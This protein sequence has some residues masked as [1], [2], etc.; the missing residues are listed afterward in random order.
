LTFETRETK[1]PLMY[2]F[3][4]PYDEE[5]IETIQSGEFIQAVRVAEEKSRAAKKVS[6][7]AEGAESSVLPTAANDL[8]NENAEST[9]S[10][11]TSEA[12]SNSDMATSGS[13]EV[14]TGDESL[15][16]ENLE[17]ESSSTEG[18]EDSLVEDSFSADPEDKLRLPDRE[19][20]VMG[21]Q[22]QNYINGNIVTS[23]P[24]PNSYDKWEIDFKIEKYPLPRAQRLH[25]MSQERRRK[26]LD[27]EFR[28]QA[29]EGSVASKKA[30]DWNRSFVQHLKRLSRA[31]KRWRDEFERKWGDKEKIVWREGRPPSSYGDMAWRDQ[32]IQKKPKE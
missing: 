18:D 7:E 31:G 24:T 20:L 8:D 23:P 6:R 15:I 29:S 2:I 10:D 21:L 25:K 28:E 19:L 30:A 5:E 17:G 12:L 11:E 1:V 13:S 16:A 9:A 26:A 14:D 4:E 27:N 22:T 32:Q 3:A